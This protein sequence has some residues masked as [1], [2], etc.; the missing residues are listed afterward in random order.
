MKNDWFE[1]WFQD[2]NDILNCMIKNMAS[3]LNAGYNYFGNCIQ[4]Q[5]HAIEEYKNQFDSEMDAFYEMDENKVQR[6]CYYNLK[7]RG[8]IS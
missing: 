7:K 5:L 2:K 8:V 3:D 1:I 6:W 4:K